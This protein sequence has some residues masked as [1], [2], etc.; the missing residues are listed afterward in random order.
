M[1]SIPC[2]V[3]PLTIIVGLRCAATDFKTS[4]ETEGSY[5]EPTDNTSTDVSKSRAAC[6]AKTIASR[7]VVVG[8][9]SRSSAITRI[10]VVSSQHLCFFSKLFDQERDLFF[11]CSLQDLHSAFLFRDG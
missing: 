1:K 2:V 9:P 8:V 3:C 5:E 6:W 4:T 11:G 10:I 7:V